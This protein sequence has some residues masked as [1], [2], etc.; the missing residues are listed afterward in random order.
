MLKSQQFVADMLE[1]DPAQVTLIAVTQQNE[2]PKGY[3]PK[4]WPTAYFKIDNADSE[5]KYVSCHLTDPGSLRTETTDSAAHAL[6]KSENQRFNPD[7]PSVSPPL[8]ELW[9]SPQ[10]AEKMGISLTSPSFAYEIILGVDG[11]Y[12]G[13]DMKAGER[14]L[15]CY[16]N[17]NSPDHDVL[18]KNCSHLRFL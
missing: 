18:M 14:L 15:T 2:A 3:E 9:L 13:F 8:E 10:A 12:N 7:F 5:S 6:W 4:M 11:H 16:Q 1:C 17:P